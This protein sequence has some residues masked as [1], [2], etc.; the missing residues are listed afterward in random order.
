MAY[1]LVDIRKLLNDESYKRPI[2]EIALEAGI[3]RQAIYY[4]ID[5]KHKPTLTTIQKICKALGVD[6][7]EEV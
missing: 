5:G 6:Y 2:G 4:I 3:S 1:K 7:L